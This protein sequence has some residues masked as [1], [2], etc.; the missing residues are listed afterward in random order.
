MSQ[1][2]HFNRRSFLGSSIAVAGTAGA[3]LGGREPGRLSAARAEA[4]EQ[5]K[6]PESNAG[7]MPYGT[8]GGAK[9]SRLLLGGNLVSGCMH[10]RDLK[11]VTPLFRAYATEDKILQTLKLAEENG[12]NTVFESGAAFVQRYNKEYGGHMQIIPSI[13]P[14][15]GQ[16]EQQLKDDIKQ[17][18][19]SGVPAL[20][21]WGAAGDQLVRA[22]EVDRIAR[23]V[24]YVKAHGIPA[25]VGGHSLEVPMACE[26]HQVP[27]D[28]YVKTLHNDDYPSA[29]R[30]ELRKEYIWL[31]GGEG[32]YDNMWCIN[33][34]E[35][36]EFMHTVTKPWIA[37]KVLAAGAIDPRQGFAHALRSGADFIAVGMFDFQIEENCELVKRL[38]EREKDR[39]RPWRA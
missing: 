5:E 37:F 21:V 24:E 6:Q 20:Y 17:Q 39:P 28:F 34:E 32:W 4:G 14:S 11:Y 31:D 22:G 16:D 3:V 25:G 15:L 35:T 12:I 7:G 9:I 33:P 2:H 27:C 23:A 1:S 18:V 30:K 19:D 38:V 10:A 26:K 29:T 36:V 8:I 13:H